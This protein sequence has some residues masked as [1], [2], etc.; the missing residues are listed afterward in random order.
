MMRLIFFML[1]L[2]RGE[3][4][5]AVLK[6]VGK[7]GKFRTGFFCNAIDRYRGFLR[8]LAEALGHFINI[9]KAQDTHWALT[10]TPSWIALFS[11]K[12]STMTPE[13]KIR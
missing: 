5:I 10:I 4:R 2:L 7:I 3:P 13:R 11:V 8:K 1:Y 12:R 6:L 9:E